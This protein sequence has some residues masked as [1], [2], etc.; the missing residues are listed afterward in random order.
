MVFEI[1]LQRFFDDFVVTMILAL[2]LK[3]LFPRRAI[4]ELSAR[5]DLQCALWERDCRSLLQGKQNR[6]GLDQELPTSA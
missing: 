1:V 4:F 3:H 2:F 5:N 6:C